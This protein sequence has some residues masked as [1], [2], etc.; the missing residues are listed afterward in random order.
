[1]TATVINQIGTVVTA[2]S[3]ATSNACCV[4]LAV[5]LTQELGFS[6]ATIAHLPCSD[7][8][9]AKQ[10]RK[11][12]L[13]RVCMPVHVCIC[14]S[15]RWGVWLVST[16]VHWHKLYSCLCVASGVRKYDRNQLC[17]PVCLLARLASML[18]GS[19][20]PDYSQSIH[21]MQFASLDAHN[22]SAFLSNRK[23]DSIFRNYL[24]ICKLSP[25]AN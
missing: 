6:P 4:S 21:Q 11:R 16:H 13:V 17:A 18:A 24:L 22:I 14:V 5:A 8:H 7:G 23:T 25:A 10:Q 2:T 15:T 12:T 1:M 20:M 9:Q 3:T 19:R